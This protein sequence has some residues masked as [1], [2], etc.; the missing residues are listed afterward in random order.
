VQRPLAGGL[1]GQYYN[2]MWMVG[3]AKMEH[4]DTTIDFDW[5]TGNV[6]PT[7]HSTEN[8]AACPI[9]RDYVSVVWSGFFKA[10]LSETYTFW[11]DSDDGS[12][13]YLQGEK[14]LDRWCRAAGPL[15]TCSLES[16]DGSANAT[17][18]C[19]AG[20]LYEVRI[21]YKEVV[22]SASIKLFYSSPSVTRQIVP[23]ARLFHS[24]EHVKG[25]PFE[26]FLEPTVVN[27]VETSAAGAGISFSTAG[28]ASHFT[29][30]ARDSYGNNR[31]DWQDTFVS[32]ATSISQSGG[33]S[34]YGQSWHG[35]VS[36]N[37]VPG[38]Y[39]VSYTVTSAGVTS[40]TTQL[41]AA[42]GLQATYY[43]SVASSTFDAHPVSARQVQQISEGTAGDTIARGGSARTESVTSDGYTVRWSGLIRPTVASLYSF[44]VKLNASLSVAPTERIRLWLDNHLVIDQWT[45]LAYV[46]SSPQGSFSFPS[47]FE[48]Y[49]L[50]LLYQSHRM[51]GITV[52]LLGGPSPQAIAPLPSSALSRALPIGLSP[53]TMQTQPFTTDLASSEVRG[54]FLTVSTAGVSSSFIVVARDPFANLRTVGGDEF[55]VQAS[56]GRVSIF[57][58]VQDLGTGRYAVTYRPR[59]SGSYQLKVHMGSSMRLYTLFVHPGEPSPRD[60]PLQGASLTI[61]TAGYAAT[62]TIQAKDAFGNLRCI[63]TDFFNVE[64][65]GPM[66]ANDAH[67]ATGVSAAGSPQTGAE[68]SLLRQ[69]LLRTRYI[70]EL[71][72]TNLGRYTAAFR[73]TYSGSY[74]LH[75][76]HVFGHGLNASFFS[77]PNL[78]DTT[79]VR[80]EPA[81]DYNWGSDLPYAEALMSDQWSARWRGLVKVPYSE[82][83]TFV[84]SIAE[85]D[86]RVRL[87][88]QDEC[89]VDQWSSLASTA[90]E[91]TVWLAQGSVASL[92]L[93]YSARQGLSAVQLR[94]MSTSQTLGVIPRERLFSLPQ[95]VKGSPFTLT[96]Y[97]AQS[98]GATSTARGNGLSLSTAG[99]FASFSIIA[100]DHFGNVRGASANDRFV[101]RARYGGSRPRRDVHA[102]VQ[103]DSS[104]PLPS[105][106]PLAPWLPP[107]EGASEGRRELQ[108]GYRAHA[109]HAQGVYRVMYEPEWKRHEPPSVPVNVDF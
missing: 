51:R 16:G 22:E 14:V 54:M 40:I 34:S 38:S 104:A 7:C 43:D 107:G 25:S 53:W 60:I 19:Q 8:E 45:S 18:S 71:P 102:S 13:L 80:L 103:I 109:R 63:G 81:V 88:I 12:R 67:T 106:I 32:Y 28:I 6:A 64:L 85:A 101:V 23:S 100:R 26:L 73:M 65:H 94:W 36:A 96:V 29:V 87:W 97:P 91:G 50:Q 5:G 86:E 74:Q 31:N 66:S 55:L 35:R 61:A 1:L 46:D 49:S 82:T 9:G 70:G 41:A 83:Y 75:V 59:I 57:G 15:D 33:S 69:H 39:Q 24:A 99:V 79:V 62:F 37:V 17:L 21:E 84:T 92:K 89:I 4:I 42:G 3:D 72:A 98:C 108:D 44:Q 105:H 48:Y 10:Q 27:V 30:V 2:N 95:H 58:D 56:D 11:L 52:E 77:D 20:Q 90:P 93:E 47:A 76:Q 68:S 78:Q